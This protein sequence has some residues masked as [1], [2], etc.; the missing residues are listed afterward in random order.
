[1]DLRL[2][3]FD[4]IYRDA[5]LRPLLVNYADWLEHGRI[6]RD[7]L[8]PSCFVRLTWTARRSSSVPAAAEVLT[9]E[10]HMP[11]RTSTDDGYL[12]FVL[13]RLQL[14]LSGPAAA[15]SIAA[16]CLQAS[17]SSATSAFDTVFATSE[18][19]I[20]LTPRQGRWPWT[21]ELAPWT[22]WTQVDWTDRIAPR[23]GSPALN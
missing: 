23:N 22:G 4:L 21:P 1:M 10:A 17:P 2:T 9:V 18:F 5:V 12:D 16:R 13:Q 8:V 11:R 6:T 7:G 20:A 3:T 14:I 15:G 19:E